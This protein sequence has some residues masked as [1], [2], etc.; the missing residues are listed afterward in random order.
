LRRSI[1]AWSA[2]AGATFC[3]PLFKPL[4]P[5]RRKRIPFRLQPVARSRLVAVTH[6]FELGA[7]LL[8]KGA[9]LIGRH[10]GHLIAVFPQPHH[11]LFGR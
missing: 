7:H 5:I 6:G 10:R 4:L 1:L 9:P 3:D 11:R 8:V 2:H